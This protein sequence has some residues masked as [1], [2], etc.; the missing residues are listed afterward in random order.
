MGCGCGS[1]ALRE[2]VGADLP[3]SGYMPPRG[4]N[5]VYELAASPGCFTPYQGAHRRDSV[6]VVG[7]N[8]E[9]ER[10]F[11]RR[12]VKDALRYA[13]ENRL[14]INHLMAQD[15]CSQVMEEFFAAA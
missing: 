9:H 11:W 3:R 5:G 8:T 2:E 13:K 10:I 15:L 12:E 4:P 1:K 6:Y 14:I 7:L